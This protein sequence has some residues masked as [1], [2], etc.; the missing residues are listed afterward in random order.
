MLWAISI[1]QTIRYFRYKFQDPKGLRLFIL[2][3]LLTSTTQL[4][5]FADDVYYYL[6]TYRLP[7]KQIHMSANARSVSTA[8]LH[9]VLVFLIQS[10]YAMR[11]WFGAFPTFKV[12]FATD[13]VRVISQ[14]SSKIAS[15][16]HLEGVDLV[17]VNDRASFYTKFSHIALGITLICTILCDAL[18]A[19]SLVYFLRNVQG[20]VHQQTRTTIQRLIFY[21]VNIGVI[22]TL[23]ALITGIT[24]LT[25]PTTAIVWTIFFFPAG[26]IYVNSL[27]V[28]LNARPSIR[29][30]LAATCDDSH[31][32]NVD[33]CYSEEFAVVSHRVTLDSQK[34]SDEILGVDARAGLFL[35]INRVTSGERY[36]D[37]FA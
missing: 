24:W 8:I 6:V 31:S 7:A 25:T 22:T 28:T 23:E 18:I 35:P 11:V 37:S 4:I 5:A 19:A 30:S 14:R 20:S 26:Q 16:Y 9:F 36:R 17:R 15:G 13:V 29:K 12:V 21:T 34:Q 1:A 33:N 27:L 10:F 32:Y 3:C 2:V